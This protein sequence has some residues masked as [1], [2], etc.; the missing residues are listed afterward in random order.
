MNAVLA[1][2]GVNRLR[3]NATHFLQQLTQSVKISPSL[4]LFLFQKLEPLQK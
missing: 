2:A 3:L 1:Y 4:F